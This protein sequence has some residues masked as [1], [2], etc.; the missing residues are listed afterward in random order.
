MNQCNCYIYKP[1]ALALTRGD[2]IHNHTRGITLRTFMKRHV[3]PERV[4]SHLVK[5]YSWDYLFIA[6]KHQMRRAKF[7]YETPVSYNKRQLATL[8]YIAMMFRSR[9]QMA[10]DM[11]NSWALVGPILAL[12]TCADVAQIIS[13]YCGVVHES[14]KTH[15]RRTLPIG[16]TTMTLEML[17]LI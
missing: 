5:E 2:F 15:K 11:I 12:H 6:A 8:L 1:N 17:N 7:W 9:C 14:V 3:V 16:C 4:I 10:H 13:L